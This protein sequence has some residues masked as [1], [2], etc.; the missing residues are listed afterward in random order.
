M[1]RNLNPKCK[2]CRRIGEKLFLKGER[3]MTPKCA[4]IKRNYPP[5]MHGQKS[6]SKKA[7]E[8]GLQLK[9]KQKAKKEYNLMEGQFRL[10]FKKAKKVKGNTSENLLKILETRLDNAV[11]RLGFADSRSQS[12][13]LVSHGHFL[14][15]GKKVNIPSYCVKTGDV[16]KI[17]EGSQRKKPLSI[18]SEK[19]KKAEVPGWLN[20]DIKE[21]TG[22]I[23]HDPLQNEIKTNFDPQAVIE[24][25]SR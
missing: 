1:G 8:Y 20:L 22:K 10:A 25:Y 18:L 15:N 17:K 12:R 16:I 13:V 5:G 19:L 4:I 7:T 24:F 3:C 11:Y 9:E 23:L 14:I 6:G 2:Q 21:L